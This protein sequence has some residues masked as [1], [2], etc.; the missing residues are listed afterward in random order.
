MNAE[1]WKPLRGYEGL[2]E[3]SNKGR[4]KSLPRNYLRK[5]KGRKDHIVKVKGK[6]LKQCVGT[7]GYYIIRI[8][9]DKKCKTK[10][11]HRLIAK[12]FLPEIKGCNI[13]NHIDGNRLNNSIENLEWTTHQGNSDNAIERGSI[14][15]KGSKHYFAKLTEQDVIQ[16][17]ELWR[18]GNYTQ[19]EIANMF[20][21]GRKNITKIVNRQRWTH[22]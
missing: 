16:I 18:S 10:K 13:V 15:M 21:V 3:V 2:Y 1:I 11:V 5:R 14:D 22:I 7:T 12:T 6:V 17:R 4:I 9:K 20:N 8:R 19:V